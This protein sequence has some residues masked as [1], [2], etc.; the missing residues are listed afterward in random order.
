VIDVC[1]FIVG[2]LPQSTSLAYNK[3]YAAR[4]VKQVQTCLELAHQAA[5]EGSDVF[6]VLAVAA[7]ESGF[8][9]GIVSPAGAVS[10][11]GIMPKYCRTA[12]GGRC[13]T[14]ADNRAHGIRYL[15][16]LADEHEL[17]DALAKYN[18]GN[19]GA[20]QGAGG[21]YAQNVMDLYS[22]LCGTFLYEKCY[23]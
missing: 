16:K 4:S 3:R 19:D 5:R 13:K 9:Q 14:P 22:R 18:A 2:T 11:M 20:C 6:L 21:Q 17:C 23:C 12:S 8:K 7:R 15:T 10:V 1:M